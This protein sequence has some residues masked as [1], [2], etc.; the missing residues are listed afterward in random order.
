[1]KKS[2]LENL[3]KEVIRNSLKV[4]VDVSNNSVDAYLILDGRVISGDS[5]RHNF[6]SQYDTW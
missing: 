6:A 3:I 4:R 1:M 5:D 2:E